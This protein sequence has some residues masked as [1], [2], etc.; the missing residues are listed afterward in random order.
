MNDAD[1]AAGLDDDQG[2]LAAARQAQGLHQGPL[3]QDD[4]RDYAD[5]TARIA[6]ALGAGNGD[7]GEAATRYVTLSRPFIPAV[8]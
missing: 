5:P 6:A 1:G 4:P 8:A 3:I 2:R 7:A